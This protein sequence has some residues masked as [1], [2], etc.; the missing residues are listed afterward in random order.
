AGDAISLEEAMRI[1][2]ETQQAIEYS[3]E[4]ERTSQEL[5]VTAQQLQEANAK[6][7]ELH[8]QKDDFL[9]HVSHEIRTPMTSIRSFSEI[10]LTEQDLPEEQARRFI[11]TIHTESVRLTKLIEEI[12]DLSALE[13]GEREWVNQSIDGEEVLD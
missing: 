13:Q 5:R 7:Q 6:L 1:A 9:A 10:L 8:R 3:H 4:L 2:D 12:L 11:S